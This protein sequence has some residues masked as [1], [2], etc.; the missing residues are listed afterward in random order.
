[1]YE[2]WS[3]G[4]PC[5]PRI[6]VTVPFL[7]LTRESPFATQTVPSLLAKTPTA[8]SLPSPSEV[9]KVATRG[10]RKLSIPLVVV[11]HRIPLGLQ[12]GR[13]R[14]RR[15]S[16]PPAHSARQHPRVCD[17]VRCLECPPRGSRYDQGSER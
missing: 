7:I 6:G 12:I 4:R 2:T 1:M 9:E 16:L 3:L 15:T 17:T 8:L 11:T 14:N 5:P 13:S 10:S